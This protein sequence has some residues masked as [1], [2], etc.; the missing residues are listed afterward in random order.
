MKKIPPNLNLVILH[1]V[2]VS[3]TE[4]C[5]N[6]LKEFKPLSHL[7]RMTPSKDFP[8]LAGV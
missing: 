3:T 1:I 7:F 6:F 5:A 8:S 2:I 4:I